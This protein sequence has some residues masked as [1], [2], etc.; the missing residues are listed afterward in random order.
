MYR[1]KRQT[2]EFLS[3]TVTNDYH[4]LPIYYNQNR[5]IKVKFFYSFSNSK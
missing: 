1:E 4:S 5:E 3:S 2:F